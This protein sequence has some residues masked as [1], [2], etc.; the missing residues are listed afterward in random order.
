MQKLIAT[1]GVLALSTAAF[2]Q[3]P[4]SETEPNDTV[5][6]A[7]FISSAFYPFGA[8]AVEGTL[9]VE[10]VDYYSFD[11]TEGQLV[12]AAVYDFTPDLGIDNDS[13]LGVFGP[14]GAFFDEDDDDGPG[15]LSSIHFFVPSSGRWTFAVTGFGDDD[16]NGTGHDDNF[17]YRFVVSVPEPASLGLL[18]AGMVFAIRRR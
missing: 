15:R 10:D 13:L 3:F 16:Y 7:N 12:T 6:S 1:V 4:L 11:L 18:L 14:G 5:G 17:D 8:V 9:D 2:A